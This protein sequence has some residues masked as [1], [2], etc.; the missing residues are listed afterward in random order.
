MRN[1][2][3]TKGEPMKTDVYQKITDRVVAEIARRTKPVQQLNARIM[4]LDTDR[5]H[6]AIRLS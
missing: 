4:K 1:R 2:Q 3:A 6:G 5:Q